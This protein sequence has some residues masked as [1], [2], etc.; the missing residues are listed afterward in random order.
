MDIIV[1]W[2]TFTGDTDSFGVLL[3]SM[4]KTVRYS[5]NTARKSCSRKTPWFGQNST[6]HVLHVR[7]EGKKKKSRLRL[8][9]NDWI[10]VDNLSENT[11]GTNPKGENGL[12]KWPRPMVLSYSYSLPPNDW[13]QELMMTMAEG[14]EN[15]WKVWFMWFLWWMCS[16]S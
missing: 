6:L 2:H 10:W 12:D 1:L 14:L 15:Y 13:H 7:F 9:W 3:N 16:T 4:S 8:H 5:N 11:T